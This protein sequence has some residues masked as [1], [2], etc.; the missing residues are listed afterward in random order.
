MSDIL[1]WFNPM[2]WLAL[3]V[4]VGGLVLGYFAWAHHLTE[5]GRAAGKAE[6][7]AEVQSKWNVERAL[8]A[9]DALNQAEIN[10]A[11]SLRRI[12]QQQENE[13][14]SE[15]QIAKAKDDA[16]VAGRAHLGVLKWADEQVASIRAA[17][18]DTAAVSQR[19][20]AAD[21]ARML[22]DVLGRAD[23]RAGVLAEYGDNAHI[24]GQL[25]VRQY[26]ALTVKP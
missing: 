6:G 21:S 26:D 9:L 25:C 10:A 19:K 20:A 7:K 13:R 3:A 18:A 22:A 23:A 4:I 16:A 11:E 8:Q 17:A 1:G 2:R 15:R 12:T 24:A 14:A 5:A